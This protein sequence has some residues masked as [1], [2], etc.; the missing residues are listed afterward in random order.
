MK[1]RAISLK[2]IFIL[3][4]IA[5]L[6]PVHTRAELRRTPV[7]PV[8]IMWMSDSSGQ[9]IRDAGLLLQPFDGQVSVAA[10]NCTVM[11]SDSCHRASILLDFGREYHG[12]LKISSGMRPSTAAI[13][14]RI[15]LG[16]SVSEAMSDVTPGHNN[17]N[18]TNDHSIRDFVTQAPWL[19]SMECGPSGFRFARIDLLDTDTDYLLKG[20][21]LMSLIDDTPEAGAFECSDSR[22]NNIWA[23]GAW[24]VRLNM[25]DYLWDGIKR[26]RLVWLGD[27][28]PEVMAINYV[29]GQHDVVRRSLDFGRDSAPLPAWMNGFA[30]YTLWWLM[31]HHDYY[32]H[33]GDLAYLRENQDY[34]HRLVEQIDSYVDESGEEKLADGARFL[35]WPTAD[36]KD[37]IH[38]GLQSMMCMAMQAA[39]DIASWLGDQRMDSVAS[40]CMKRMEKFKVTPTDATQAVSLRLLAGLSDNPEADC[41]TIIDN[42]LNSFSPFFGYYA[43]EALA[44]N[45]HTDEAMK[46]VSNYWGAMLDLGATS[47][48][49]HLNYPD[50]ANAGGIDKFVPEGKFDIHKDGGDHCYVGLRQSLCHGWAGGPTPWMQRYILGVQPLEPGFRKVLVNP[51]LGK[52]AW[53]KGTVPTPAGPIEVDAS[54]DSAGKTIVKIKAPKGVQ[55][56]RTPP[57]QNR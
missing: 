26:D 52:L 21:Q 7:A 46:M 45:G 4:L 23:T 32:L 40:G 43:I 28:H 47:F 2:V 17:G 20:V 25:Q 3:I 31:I 51:H 22:L 36:Q 27:M 24:T 30:S 9:Y 49:E 16:E 53:A 48:W 35:D 18:A 8:R 12:S 34:I 19:G 38:D 13:H 54:K 6:A 50:V 33:H 1:H 15:C 55:V 57:S 10:N 5:V 42:G 44:R 37:V 39:R 41:R 14:L 11:R 56:L 29:W